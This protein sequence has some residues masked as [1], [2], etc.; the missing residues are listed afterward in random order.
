MGT[1]VCEYCS[2]EFQRKYNLQVHQRKTKYCIEK[3]REIQESPPATPTQQ[4]LLELIGQLQKTIDRLAEPTG[5]VGNSRNVVLHNLQP[6]TDEDLQEHLQNLTLDYI[7]EGAKGY[8]DFAGCYPFK[9]RLLCTDKARKKLRYKGDDGEFI[10]DGGGT[11]LIKRFFQAIAPRNE[12]IINAEYTLLHK[13]VQKIAEGG[14]ASNSD[15]AGLLTKAT[16][17]QQLLISCQEAARGE[18][19]SLTKEFINHLTKLL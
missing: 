19:N 18:E 10:D 5:G 4:T 14:T 16:K 2:K 8:A 7:Q 13:E 3:Q 6:L 9:D 15:L 1:F 12:E 11:K 17:L